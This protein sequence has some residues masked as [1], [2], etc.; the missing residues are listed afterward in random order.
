MRLAQQLSRF[1]RDEDGVSTINFLILF[2]FLF[3]LFLAVFEAGWL[4]TRWM[5]LERGLDIAAREVRVGKAS[6]LTHD[7]LKKSVCKHSSILVNCE[8]D[9]ILEV[10]EMDLSKSYPQNQANCADRTGTID[11]TISFSSGGRNRIMFVRAC[12][13]VD[14]FAPGVGLG[15]MLPKDTSGGFQMVSY[16][17]FMNEP[18]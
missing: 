5:M 4:A 6:A 17:A 10:V 8:R 9:M 11:P 12:M 2:P 16:T 7:A 3:L 15:L 1:R 18:L 13:I 14:P